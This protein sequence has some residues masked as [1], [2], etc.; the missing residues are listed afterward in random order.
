MQQTVPTWRQKGALLLLA[1]LMLL[2]FVLLPQ[3]AQA[4]N[5]EPEGYIVISIETYDRD[6]DKTCLLYTSRCV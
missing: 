3:P 1:L 5:P 2:T 6:T 4:D